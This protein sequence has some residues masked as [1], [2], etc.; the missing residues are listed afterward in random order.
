MS[1]K[2]VSAVFQVDG[3]IITGTQQAKCDYLV[4]VQDATNQQ[5]WR[6]I[7][8]EL[9]GVDAVHGMEQ[10]LAM[11]QNP[12]FKSNSN[13]VRKARLVAK[14][15]PSYNNNPKVEKLR[16]EFSKAQL[17]FRHMKSGAVDKL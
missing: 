13:K 6:E 11:V 3:N 15:F 17:D 12:L 4:L 10:L 9:K 5:D 2:E 1:K 14:S 8:I 16:K 7:F